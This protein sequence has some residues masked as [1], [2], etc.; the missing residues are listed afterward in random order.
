M[1]RFTGRRV[2]SAVVAAAVLAGGLA[3]G[4]GNASAAGSFSGESANTS[5]SYEDANADP[6]SFILEAAGAIPGV[7]VM[8]GSVVVCGSLVDHGNPCG[9]GMQPGI[10]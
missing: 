2:A 6:V 10:G 1:F 8:V 4:A 7:F 9:L 5:G 3:A